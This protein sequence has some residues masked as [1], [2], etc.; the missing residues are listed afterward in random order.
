MENE[1][2]LIIECDMFEGQPEFNRTISV[3]DYDVEVLRLLMKTIGG[4]PRAAWVNYLPIEAG[5]GSRCDA[6]RM[7]I[8]YC[9]NLDG[10]KRQVLESVEL[11]P[12]K[13]GTRKQLAQFIEDGSIGTMRVTIGESKW[14]YT[15]DGTG[16]TITEK[17]FG[18]TVNAIYDE[19]RENCLKMLEGTYDEGY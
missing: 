11:Q 12:S 6:I 17:Q 4:L 9:P 2:Q 8:E 13:E 19:T 14:Y 18:A 15:H 10:S 5:D 3:T 16:A 1:Y 7:Y